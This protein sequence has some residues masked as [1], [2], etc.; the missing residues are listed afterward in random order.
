MQDKKNLLILSAFILL[1]VS[2][3]VLSRSKTERSLQQKIVQKTLSEEKSLNPLLDDSQEK[4]SSPLDRATERI[5]KKDFDIFI[6]PKNSPV[7]P[8]RFSGYHTGVD[9]EI[10]PEELDREVPIK[11]VC[12]GK[13]IS[14]QTADGYGGLLI[15]DCLIENE[16]I[17]V[18]YGHLNL[19][20]IAKNDRDEIKQGEIIGNLGRDKTAE[21][22]NERKHLHLSLHRGSDIDIRGY[23]QNETELSEWIDP[24]L[25]FC[26]NSITI[27]D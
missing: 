17:T 2:L 20:S 9:F 19:E 14:K 8:E 26:E 24:C 7:Q 23:V 10:F 6:T 21:T 12:D 11:A 1:I 3:F 5:T 13:I 22:D 15:Q 25:Y 16:F 4:I 18:V 27:E